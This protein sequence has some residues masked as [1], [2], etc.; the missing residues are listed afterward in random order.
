M[1][2]RLFTY[3]ES[4]TTDLILRIHPRIIQYIN[5]LLRGRQDKGKLPSA[6]DVFHDVLCTFLDNRI[7][8]RSDK[9]PAYLFRA[10]R[11]RCRNILGRRKEENSALRLDSLSLAAR[12]II[13]AADFEGESAGDDAPEFFASE[14]QQE[15]PQISEILDFSNS[16]TE[17]TRD[18]FYLSRIE[19]LTQEE[20]ASRLGISTRAVQKHLQASVQQYRRHFGLQSN[21]S[22]KLS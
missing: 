21:N 7:E 10:V 15:I 14:T 20:I 8:I 1:D 9:V 18:I 5:A 3:S 4:E 17:R 13:A 19:G 12:E 11:N 2:E 16:L 22:S 6:E